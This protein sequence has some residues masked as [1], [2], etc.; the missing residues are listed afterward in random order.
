MKKQDTTKPKTPAPD[1]EPANTFATT[2]AQLGKGSS[3][4]EL[5]TKLTEAVA[6]ARNTHKK[7]ELKY[8]LIIAPVKGTEGT[9][10]IVTDDVA[11][12]LPSIDRK[13]TL[14]FTDEDGTLS[15]KDPNQRDWIDEAE[16]QQGGGSKAVTVAAGSVLSKEDLRAAA[17]G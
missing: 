1:T 3:L 5:S 14:F 17:Q 13:P 16:A 9:Q 15:R 12:K 11:V 6:A 7:A 4:A 2:L 8:K 10:V